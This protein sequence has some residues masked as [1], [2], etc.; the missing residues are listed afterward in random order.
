MEMQTQKEGKKDGDVLLFKFNVYII[1]QVELKRN[2]TRDNQ[3]LFPSEFDY[4][5]HLWK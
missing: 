3:R 2:S 5:D 1:L 4:V